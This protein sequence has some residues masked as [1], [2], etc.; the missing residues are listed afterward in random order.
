MIKPPTSGLRG[1]LA[2][3]VAFA[4]PLLAAAEPKHDFYLCLNLGGQGQSVSS[5]AYVKSG[6]YRSTDRVTFEHVGFTH[7]RTISVVSDPRDPNC[8]FL[9]LLDGVLRSA[10]RG[11]TW[12]RVTDWRMTEG[13]GIAVDP[14]APDHVYVAL[15]DGIGVSRDHGDSWQRMNGS[16]RRAYTES[17]V[18]DR[19]RAGRVL[20][21]TELGIYLTEDGARTWKLVQATTK[22]TY[23][24][25]QSP[26]DP[27]VFLAA[28]SAEGVFRSD[29]GGR[30]WRRLAG[31]PTGHTMHSAVFDPRDPHRLVVAGWGAGVQVSDDDGRTWSDRS[32]G[33]P[34]REIWAAIADPD[35][36]GRLYAGPHLSPI[37]VSDDWGRT[38]RP[39]AFDNA[40]VFGLA[41]LPRP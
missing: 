5:R 21:G 6:L 19:T 29:D 38:W 39:L 37:Q 20:A 17:L 27:K 1:W 23:D 15:P 30:S 26:H 18:V 14:N 10:D 22:V 24:L 13:K 33:L 32:A 31:L 8:L 41:F 11:R 2:R 3:L 40:L 25:R 9:A 34:R 12:K 36:P 28:T 16:I 35:F 4:A 7:I